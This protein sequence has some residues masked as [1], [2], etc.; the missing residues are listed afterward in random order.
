MNVA[1]LNKRFDDEICNITDD[2]I[3]EVLKCGCNIAMPSESSRYFLD[4]RI[5]FVENSD[6]LLQK[7]DIIFVV[8]GDG[9][10]IH[11]AKK[12][13]IFDKKVFGINGGN[14][15]FLCGCEKNEMS[16]ISCVLNGNYKVIDAMM[17]EVSVNGEVFT[18]LNDVVFNRDINS[19]ILKYDVIR[20]GKIFCSHEADGLIFATPI[21]STAYSFSVGG[22]IVESDVKCVVMTP[23]CP[24]SFFSRSVILG[25]DEEIIVNV[26][27]V[28]NKNCEFYISVDGVPCK[29]DPSKSN[30]IKI[31]KSKHSAKIIRLTGQNFYSNIEKKLA[32]K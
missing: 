20:N 11:Y 13:A 1:I 6:D 17:L 14:L 4:D 25:A 28:S 2:V 16:K 5:T 23:I 18:A 27:T 15:G 8:G 10:L 31:R 21:G 22:A 9:T 24:H 32:H 3:R 12:A 19:P 29:L 26:Q 7:S 30:N